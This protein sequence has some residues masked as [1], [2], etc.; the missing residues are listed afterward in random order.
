MVT[1]DDSNDAYFDDDDADSDNADNL[2]YDVMM[3]MILET[4]QVSKML[5]GLSVLI[6]SRRWKGEKK[7]TACDAAEML[8]LASL[9]SSYLVA[10][11]DLPLC[12]PQDS[13]AYSACRCLF[14]HK[15]NCPFDIVA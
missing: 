6:R 8:A 12:Y 13:N 15:E 9:L 14:E 2:Y 1:S 7:T 5:G 4:S 11:F 3:L 10:L